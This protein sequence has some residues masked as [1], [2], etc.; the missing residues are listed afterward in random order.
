MRELCR[1]FQ[2][3]RADLVRGKVDQRGPRHTQVFGNAIGSTT[4]QGVFR[5]HDHGDYG[6]RGSRASFKVSGSQ[7]APS[8]VWNS[9]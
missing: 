1:R 4:L 8:P 9:P 6:A 2:D 3:P 7:H 5:A